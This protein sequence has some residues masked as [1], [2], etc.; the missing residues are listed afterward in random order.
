M[1]STTSS[2]S[3]DVH[4]IINT[5]DEDFA[6]RLSVELQYNIDNQSPLTMSPENSD[7]G[8]CSDSSND[9]H[10]PDDRVQYKV[11]TIK[12]IEAK[13]KREY[14]ND[15]MVN[16]MDIISVY[17][18]SQKNIYTEAKN[19]IDTRLYILSIPTICI[20]IGVSIINPFIIKYDCSVI[21]I[22]SLNACLAILIALI[23]YLKMETTSNNYEI[24]ASRYSNLQDSLD[25]F[26]S[27]ISFIHSKSEKEKLVF[28]KM[29]KIDK[30]IA[31][32][33]DETKILLP[34]YIRYLYPKISSINIFSS[35]Y[36]IEIYRKHLV[37]LLKSIVNETRYIYAK[38]DSEIEMKKQNSDYMI[39]GFNR[40]KEKNRLKSLAE[41]KDQ[42]KAEIIKYK[43][44]YS[45]IDDVFQ[46]EIKNKKNKERMCEYLFSWMREDINI[47][48]D[49]NEKII[50]YD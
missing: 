9:E 38:W 25:T 29:K 36:S 43:N 39:N 16:E 19:I 1:E 13:L 15:E 24:I 17:V 33:K 47:A 44:T 6:R 5:E 2:S 21:L 46:Q 45:F 32:I 48:L 27:K 20:S 30:K 8:S 42:V 34:H 3:T 37:Q 14:N 7:S 50:K 26:S 41:T 23:G 18:K 31:D 11:I 49:I 40:A 10:R 28:N 4:I 35:I 12:E 22:T